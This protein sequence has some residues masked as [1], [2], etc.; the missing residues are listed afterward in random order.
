MVWC[1]VKCSVNVWSV[2]HQYWFATLSG[3]EIYTPSLSC[4]A[5]GRYQLI[6]GYKCLAHLL[7]KISMQHTTVSD[8]TVLS[9]GTNGL[10]EA[11][12]Y[13]MNK[14]TAINQRRKQ[15]RLEVRRSL[16]TEYI[17]NTDPL[18]RNAMGNK[19]RQ[20]L[21]TLNLYIRQLAVDS[22]YRSN[23]KKMEQIKDI[24]MKG[25]DLNQDII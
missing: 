2:H 23:F 1:K 25:I 19:R 24:L 15:H 14:S 11:H 7:Q 21:K 17:S 16:D 20:R 4:S 10:Y 3:N 18:E 9:C 5:L 22:K 8:S 6:Y 13:Y 12:P